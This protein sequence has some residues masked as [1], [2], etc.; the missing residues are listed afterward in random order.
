MDTVYSI[1]E[2]LHESTFVEKLVYD[3]GFPD[4]DP[5]NPRKN[6]EMM[7]TILI[8]LY[9]TEWADTLLYYQADITDDLGVTFMTVKE[10]RDV[11]LTNALLKIDG[12]CYDVAERIARMV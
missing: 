3:C 10:M 4:Y 1:F 5:K 11:Y 8:E 9:D 6:P 12:V 2:Y 7:H